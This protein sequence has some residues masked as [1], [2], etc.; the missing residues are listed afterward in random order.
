MKFIFLSISLLFVSHIYAKNN[1]ENI[2]KHSF[3]EVSLNKIDLKKDFSNAFGIKKIKIYNSSFNF[4]NK[5]SL[6]NPPKNFK[7][8]PL[9][10]NQDLSFYYSKEQNFNP[11]LKYSNEF[12]GNASNKIADNQYFNYNVNLPLNYKNQ[13]SQNEFSFSYNPNHDYTKIDLGIQK[14][15][16]PNK[17]VNIQDLYL[18]GKT[19]TWVGA[20]LLSLTYV[21]ALSY[22]VSSF[23][24][25]N[26]E[27]YFEPLFFAAAIPIVLIGTAF[28][29]VG[30]GLVAKARRLTYPPKPPKII[31]PKPKI[32]PLEN[33]GN[34]IKVH[35]VLTGVGIGLL[36]IGTLTLLAVIAQPAKSVNVLHYL[37][38]VPPIVSGSF[39]IHYG[40][41][42]KQ[43]AIK[44]KS[45]KK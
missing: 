35:K 23:Q 21:G 11:T 3:Y 2:K 26:N 33:Y 10:N 8:I 43:K 31:I 7:N 5:Q 14:Y 39:L 22:L 44:L 16:K 20:G 13:P 36:S 40:K 1:Y 42:F 25:A 37:I 29:G 27:Q 4:M 30:Q 15:Q 9:V 6:I 45:Y 28:V 32:P 17:K 18:K 19:L 24:S 34:L 38:S 41:Q 12:I